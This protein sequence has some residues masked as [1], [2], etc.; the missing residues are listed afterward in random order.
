MA[1]MIRSLYIKDLDVVLLHFKTGALLFGFLRVV[2]LTYIYIYLLSESFRSWNK[3]CVS[4]LL[5]L[6]LG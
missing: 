6:K 5:H 2:K 4:C 3:R 1:L